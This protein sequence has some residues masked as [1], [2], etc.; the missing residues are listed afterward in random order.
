MSLIEVRA[1]SSPIL[2][3]YVCYRVTVDKTYR[4]LP[5][6]IP[7]FGK[8]VKLADEQVDRSACTFQ[9]YGVVSVD[10]GEGYY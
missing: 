2:I 4:V 10:I 8:K 1:L 5:S 7:S 9:V 6:V 3:L